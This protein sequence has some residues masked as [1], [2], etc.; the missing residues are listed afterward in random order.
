[1]QRFFAFLFAAIFSLSL[2]AKELSGPAPDFTLT[3]L[4]GS[5]VKLSDL[6][7]QVVMLN[8]W[9]SWCGPCRQEMPLLNDIYASYKKAGFVLLGINVDEI[10]DDAKDFM[11]KTP[12]NFPV[13]LDSDGKVAGLYKNQA[14]PSSYFIDRKGN[15]VHLHQGYKPGEEA[16]YKKV[17]KKLLAE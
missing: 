2:Q 16:E 6:K 3:A 8:F 17:I 12:V 13:L 9:A 15:L 14:M 10:V 1:M 4:D 11:N 7:G 5:K